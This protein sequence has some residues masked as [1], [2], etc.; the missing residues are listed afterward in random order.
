MAEDFEYDLTAWLEGD[1]QW[2]RH[3]RIAHARRHLSP[4]NTLTPYGKK[5]WEAVIKANG[6][7]P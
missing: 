1:R 5:F 7:K 2:P 4:S 6:E 3:L